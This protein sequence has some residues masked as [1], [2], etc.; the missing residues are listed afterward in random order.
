MAREGSS[1]G[2]SNANLDRT[3]PACFHLKMTD[4]TQHSY[5]GFVSSYARGPT[6]YLTKYVKIVKAVTQAPYLE[7][8]WYISQWCAVFSLALCLHRSWVH[9]CYVF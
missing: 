7:I 4:I 9:E 1:V 2:Q 6:I 3:W 5:S 8:Y